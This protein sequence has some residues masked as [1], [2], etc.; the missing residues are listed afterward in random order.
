MKDE[1]N[2][3]LTKLKLVSEIEESGAYICDKEHSK[4]LY[5]YITNLQKDRDDLDDYNRHLHTKLTN[6]QTIEREYSS[7]LSE[8]VELENKITNLQEENEKSKEYSEFYKDMS[9]KWKELSG[10]FKKSCE[11][12]KTR[13]EKAIEYIT[14][15]QLYTNYQWGKSQYVKILKDLLNILQ[16]EQNE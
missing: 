5:D 16:G 15:E 8:N 6:L 2:L 14:T 3:I 1:I 11:D 13:N 7:L 10:V 9:D 12:Y 4:I